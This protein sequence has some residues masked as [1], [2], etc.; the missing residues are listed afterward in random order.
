MPTKPMG[1]SQKTPRKNTTSLVGQ[2]IVMR[3]FLAINELV[4]RKVIRGVATFTKKYDIDRRNFKLLEANPERKQF[5]VGW[6]TFIVKDFGINLEWLI[7]GK[8]PMFKNE[9]KEE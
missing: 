1:S 3:F 4:N 6:V 5:D 9:N 8:G 7:F 2:Q